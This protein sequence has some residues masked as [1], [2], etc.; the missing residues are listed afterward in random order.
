MSKLEI[1][2]QPVP[3]MP[4]QDRPEGC[5]EVVWRYTHNPIIP[6]DLLKTSNSI[7]NSAVVPFKK[8]K[9]NFAGV[10]RCDDT[11]RRMRIHVG[12]SVDGINWEIN[13]EDVRFEGADPEI[14]NWVYGYDPRVAKVDDR[15]IVTWCNGYYGPTIGVAW[16]KDFETFHQ[17]ENAFLPYNRNGVMFPRKINGNYAMLSR[18]SDTGHT[19]FGDIFYS[20]SPDLEFWGRHRHVMSPAPFEDSAWQCMKV[21]AGPIPI[22]TSEGWLLIYHGVL[23]SCNGYVY[24]FGS[25]LLDLEQPWK[26]IARS[27]PY[28]ISPR[29]IYE[30]TGDVPNVTF[31]CAAL[32]DLESGR[33]AIYYGCADTVTSLCFGY[34]PE[35]VEWTKRNSIIDLP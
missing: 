34:I 14:A 17:M 21:G 20:E 35:I 22:E 9:Y 27:G 19:P 28:L 6:R 16:T 29:E 32:H 7:F 5:E 30:L 8:G 3:D 12:F 10:F 11:N 2:G 33:I 23:R 13:E 24:A 31:P 26:V 4:W 15:Y 1:K 18:P 25:A